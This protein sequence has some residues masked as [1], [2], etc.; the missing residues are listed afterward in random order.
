TSTSSF[1]SNHLV[2]SRYGNRRVASSGSGWIAAGLLVWRHEEDRV[3]VVRALVD[4]AGVTGA[5]RVGR[6][7]AVRRPGGRRRGARRGRGVLPRAPLR[8]AA[9]IAV[10]AARRDR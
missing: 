1:N 2:A 6:A 7:P 5:V 10:P 8:P 9:G 3:P 4:V